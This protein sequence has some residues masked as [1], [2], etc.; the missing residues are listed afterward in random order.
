VYQAGWGRQEIAIVPKGY[1]MQGFG[2]WHHRARGIQSPLHARALFLQDAKGN[3]VIFCCLDLGYVTYAMRSGICTALHERMGDVFNEASLVLTCTH[4]HSGP[5]G[6]T[7]DAMYNIVTPGFVPGHVEKIVE[8]TVA[9]IVQ[10]WQSAA[11]TDL[12]LAQGTFEDDVPVAWNR[13]VQA[14]NRNPE[15]T[16]RAETETHLAVDRGM[17]L[18]SLRREGELQSLLSLFGVHA[19]CVGNSLL[20]HDGDN[21]G[22]AALQAEKR[23]AE[24]GAKGAVAIFAQG[25]AGDVS[26]HY[27][28]PGDVA[29]RKQIKGDAEYAYAERNGRYQSER[30]LSLLTVKNEECIQGDIDAILSYADFTSVKADPEFANGNDDAWTSEPCHGVAF[31]AGTPVDGPGMPKAL[32]RISSV[33]AGVVKNCR[34]KNI[35]SMSAEDQAYYRRIYSAQGPKAILMEAG[36]KRVLGQPLEKIMLPGFAD[37]TVGEM[38]RQARSGAIRKS[39]MVP[40]VLPLQIVTIGQ[41][42]IVCCPGEF[43][44]TAG[45]RVQ[46]VVAEKLKGRG[47]QHVLICTYC[48]E[49]MGYVTT[50]EEYQL[51]AYEGGHTIF[52]QWTLAAFQT[53]FA[54]LAS[55]LVKAE[56]ERQHDRVMRPAPAPAEELALRTNL[57]VPR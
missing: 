31:F 8:A 36:R 43:T 6:C 35:D 15:V 44:T 10:A 50:N 13:S 17:K 2:M 45:Q 54:S 5:G 51:Q 56:G 26:P 47:I 23:L 29:R 48:N 27:H 30:A 3:N 14:Y 1:A 42:A 20:K 21:K 33:I 40:T 38:K 53:R 18:F 34:M 25:T 11:P 32:A 55:E 12:G 28:G 7:H 37:P 41:V 46:Q 22:Y 52:G 16:P 9:A 19:T 57:P 4:T 24:L 49:Y 39:A